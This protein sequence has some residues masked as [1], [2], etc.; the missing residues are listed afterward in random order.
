M[1]RLWWRFNI[2]CRWK[3]RFNSRFTLNCSLCRFSGLNRNARSGSASALWLKW[4]VSRL[5]MSENRRSRVRHRLCLCLRRRT[6][7]F[8]SRRPCRLK[9]AVSGKRACPVSSL[10]VPVSSRSAPIVKLMFRCL[11]RVIIRRA[12]CGARCSRGILRNLWDRRSTRTLI[13][14]RL[15]LMR[16][17]T[18]SAWTRLLIRWA[19]KLP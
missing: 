14:R 12:A 10:K 7:M 1:N 2:V 19:V 6:P 15:L 8:R 3:G 17:G 5:K 4:N 18:C 11:C 9:R 13:F 16:T